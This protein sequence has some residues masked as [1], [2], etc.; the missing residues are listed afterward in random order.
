MKRIEAIVF[1]LFVTLNLFAQED[2]SKNEF[3]DAIEDNSFFIEESYNQE[4]RVVQHISNVTYR[5][6]PVK[7]ILY[8]FTQEWPVQEYHQQFSYTIPYS[9]IDGNS[10]K[11][12]GDIMLNY[13][14]QLFYKDDWACVSPR[15]SLILPTGNSKKALGYGV[16]GFQFNFPASKRLSN[17]WVVHF[18]AGTTLFPQVEG[19]LADNTTV[20]R[21]LAFYNLGG[22]V[23]WLA[24]QN[25]NFM[26]EY[27]AN[28]N[29][30]INNLGNID[31]SVENIVNPGIRCAINIGKLQIVPGF[32]LPIFINSSEAKTGLFFYLSFEH[33]Y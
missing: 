19:S 23:I 27:M 13:R 12:V 6:Y 15:L 17:F 11:G 28:F 18:N 5:S 9:F 20:K 8:T 24:N 2:K 30:E 31:R 7:S 1:I 10:I 21:N 14:Y 16:L 26:L 29:T 25:F 22:S 4:E 33:P 32:S 3:V